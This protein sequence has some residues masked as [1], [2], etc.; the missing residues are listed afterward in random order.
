MSP[1][2]VVP[3]TRQRGRHFHPAAHP[4]TGGHMEEVEVVE[5]DDIGIELVEE[6]AEADS[7]V[8]VRIRLI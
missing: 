2:A 1:A 5:V 6:S 8:W 4:R 3:E 7:Y